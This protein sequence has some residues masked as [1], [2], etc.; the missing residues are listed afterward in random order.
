MKLENI[1]QIKQKGIEDDG[2]R[3]GGSGCLAVIDAAQT[4]F[5]GPLGGHLMSDEDWNATFRFAVPQALTG[6][7]I[8][9]SAGAIVFALIHQSTLSAKLI[10]VA[11]V[12]D[13]LDGPLATKLRAQTDFGALFDY[14]A[15]YLCYIVAPVVLSCTLLRSSDIGYPALL[16]TVPLLTGAIRYSRNAVLLR[17]ESFAQLG[18]PGLLTVCYALFV[19]GAVLVDLED[20]LGTRHFRTL[21]YAIVPVLSLLMISRLR[22]PKLTVSKAVGIPVVVFLLC[23]PFL[24]SKLLAAFMLCAVFAYTFVS[25]FLVAGR[26]TPERKG[27]ASK[28]LAEDSRRS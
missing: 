25:P 21:L 11:T 20:M 16:L 15:D 27:M 18:F 2:N 28:Q 5:F 17:T 23:L 14:F 10:A 26:P 12:T 24:V 1:Q 19:V 13:I 7:R 6:L 4:Y 8:I 22:Y 3:A 9:L